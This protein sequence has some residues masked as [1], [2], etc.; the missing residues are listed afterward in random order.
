MAVEYLTERDTRSREDCIAR[1]RV[2]RTELP[3]KQVR[4]SRASIWICQRDQRG[5]WARAEVNNRSKRRN[6]HDVLER[7]RVRSLVVITGSAADTRVAVFCNSIGKA[8]PRSKVF[9]I[10]INGRGWASWIVIASAVQ[11]SHRGSRETLRLC[12]RN[13]TGH[14]PFAIR[15]REERIP[16]ES[17]ADQQP[18][19]SF[20][21]VLHEEAFPISRNVQVKSPALRKRRHSAQLEVC[22]GIAGQILKVKNSA[23]LVLVSHGQ[24]HS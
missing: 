2:G 15:V 10:V 14:S 9:Q 13:K 18:G 6:T 22:Q 4:G 16:A 12:S 7:N 19:G 23:L 17:R 1:A 8:Q 3:G 24:A 5:A 11:H 21:V 20:P